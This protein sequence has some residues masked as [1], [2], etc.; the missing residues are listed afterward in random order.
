M[1]FYCLLVLTFP[2]VLKTIYGI[3]SYMILTQRSF[4]VI[5]YINSMYLYLKYL[6]CIS[7]INF[8]FIVTDKHAS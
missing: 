4:V 6:N 8:H 1:S 2:T 7:K 3:I 5:N